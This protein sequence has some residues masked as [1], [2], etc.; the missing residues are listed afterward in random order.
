MEIP[1]N[2]IDAFLDHPGDQISLILLYGSSTGMVTWRADRLWAYYQ[3]H[4]GTAADA[5]CLSANML[6]A[7]RIIGEFHSPSLF[8]KSRILRI[9]DISARHGVELAELL[10]HPPPAGCV[11]ILQGA[12]VNKSSIL[13]KNFLASSHAGAIACYEDTPDSMRQFIITTLRQ[14]GLSPSQDAL[15]MLV[16]RLSGDRMVAQ[17]TLETLI[18]YC[19]CDHKAVSLDDVSQ[20]LG[21]LR[22]SYIHEIADATATGSPRALVLY[23]DCRI[24]GMPADAILAGIANHF[25]QLQLGQEKVAKGVSAQIVTRQ[26]GIFFRRQNDF[27]A[28][29]GKWRKPDLDHALDALVDMI[30]HIRKMPASADTLAGQSITALLHMATNQHR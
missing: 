20:I 15:A 18:L 25:L 2:R 9:R 3:N 23:R 21:H 5:I 10:S 13:Y 22:T 8:A 12:E 26:M 30:T 11:M 17:K 6:E 7:G 24:G 14:A 4:Y 19:G 28:A 16:E 27:T 29:L 1:K